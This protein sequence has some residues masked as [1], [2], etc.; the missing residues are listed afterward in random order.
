VGLF[1]F[2]DLEE[3]LAKEDVSNNPAKGVIDWWERG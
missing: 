1:E 3:Y 2:M